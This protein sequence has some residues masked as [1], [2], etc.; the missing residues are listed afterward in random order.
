[1]VP[2]GGFYFL[3]TQFFQCYSEIFSYQQLRCLA[4]GLFWPIL[5]ADSGQ[6]R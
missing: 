3:V 4:K 5:S 1:M 6:K 2:G